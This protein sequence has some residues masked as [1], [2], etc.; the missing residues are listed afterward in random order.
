MKTTICLVLALIVVIS[1][2]LYGSPLSIF[3]DLPSLI[4]VLPCPLLGLLS[5]FSLVEILSFNEDV[6]KLGIVST[7]LGGAIGL[8]VGMIQMLQNMSDPSSIGP[9]MAL[10]L[11]CPFYSL[12]LC[13][14]FIFGKNSPKAAYPIATAFSFL[15]AG[16]TFIALFILILSFA[17]F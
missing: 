9:A 16:A 7:C 15:T 11:L 13:L 6:K 1:G 8:V 12:V 17:K 14:V 5:R 10:S 3:I 2:I 4:I